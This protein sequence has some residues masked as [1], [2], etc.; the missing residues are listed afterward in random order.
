M[1]KEDTE[2]ILLQMN[3]WNLYAI[4]RPF[5][6]RRLQQGFTKLRMRCQAL[7]EK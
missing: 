6:L 7:A 2:H 3:P 4:Y 5:M 1:V